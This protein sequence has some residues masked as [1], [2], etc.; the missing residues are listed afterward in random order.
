MISLEPLH[1]EP[2]F[3]QENSERYLALNY[4]EKRNFYVNPEVQVQENPL[5]PFRPVELIKAHTLTDMF[6]RQA[7]KIELPPIKLEVGLNNDQTLCLGDIAAALEEQ[8]DED[9]LALAM[10]DDIGT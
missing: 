9:E 3:R 10:C 8:V 1:S 2:Q 7:K 5:E 6:K 4:D